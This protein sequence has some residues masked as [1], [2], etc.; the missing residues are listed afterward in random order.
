MRELLVNRGRGRPPPQKK[1]KE[2]TPSGRLSEFRP[3]SAAVAGAG[4]LRR[5]L[6]GEELG[7]ERAWPGSEFY[8]VGPLV[9]YPSYDLHEDLGGKFSVNWVCPI[10]D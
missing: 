9:G 1:K 5:N 2:S 3:A 4:G 6:K 10:L 7:P 8:V